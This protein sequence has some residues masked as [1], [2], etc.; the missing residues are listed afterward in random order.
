MPVALIVIFKTTSLLEVMYA[1]V[2]FYLAMLYVVLTM[3]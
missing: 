2:T 1:E 3:P